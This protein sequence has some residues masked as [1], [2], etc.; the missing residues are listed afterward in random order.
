MASLVNERRATG[1]TAASPA[2]AIAT[3]EPAGARRAT[4]LAAL[5]SAISL[6]AAF[7]PLDLWPLAWVAPLGWLWLCQRPTLSGRRPYTAIWFSGFVFWMLTLHWLRYPHPATSIGWLAASFYFAFYIPAFVALVRAAVWRHRW[8]LWLAAPVVWTGLELLRGHLLTGYTGASLGHTQYRWLALIQVADFA[9]AY[10]V[11][12]LVMLGAA[13]LDGALFAARR[14]TARRTA[15]SWPAARWLPLVGASLVVA[16]ACGY[17]TWRLSYQPPAGPRLK[18]ALIQGSI[19]TQVKVD[20][21]QRFVVYD[22]YLALCRQAKRQHAD[23]DL[24]IW[25]ETMFREPLITF[26]DDFAPPVDAEW[27]ADDA[28][29]AA[30]RNRQFIG[31]MTRDLGVAQILGIDRQH[32][33]HRKV[34]HFNTAL[35]V[36][37]QGQV[38]GMYAKM[39][40]VMFGEYIPLGQ[41]LPWL[42]EITPVAAALTP[43]A[44]PAV[45]AVGGLR[46]APNICFENFLPHLVRSQVRQLRAAGSEPDV[47]V[48]LTNDGWFRGSSELDLH[49]NCAVFRAVELRKPFLIAANTGFSAWVAPT[50]QIRA[51]GPRHQPAV[52]MADVGRDGR[53]SPYDQWGDL[54][55]GLCLAA[56]LGIAAAALWPRRWSRLPAVQRRS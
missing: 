55:A 8:P 20:P 44:G 17:G 6:W 28:R 30:R 54:F 21:N 26:G 4:L 38:A 48:N 10:G 34:E 46:L 14:T 56:S 27:T 22:H 41:W 25:P 49:L 7:P 36:D 5:G 45:F 24:M 29:L 3:A 2:R 32:L 47:L 18:V 11:S 43:G 52:V 35:H 33:V 9:G 51:R 13:A 1:G 16:L 37:R 50:G 42:Y 19:D 23:L 15:A 53:Q 12:F 31:G 39:H 40:P